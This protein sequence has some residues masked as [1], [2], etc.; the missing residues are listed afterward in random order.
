MTVYRN[1]DEIKRDEAA[2]ISIG[3]FDGVH[4]AHRQII[5]KVLNLS[6]TNKLRSFLITF[7]PHPQ[8]V[9]KNKSPEI[10]LLTTTRE[11]LILFEELGI[12]N[13]L[14]INFTREFSKT[15]AEDF[16]RKLVFAKIGLNHLVI[17]YDHVFGKNREG[18]FET[19]LNLGIELHFEIHRVEEIDVDGMAVSST[20]IRHFLYE[21]NIEEAN[22]LLGYEYSFEGIVSV[23]D[24]RGRTLGFPTIN[25]KPLAV[26]KAMPKDGVYCVK[27][28]CGNEW[29]YGMMNMGYRPTLTRGLTKVLEVN[30]FDFERDIYGKEV[31]VKF[32]KK[33]R[34]EKKFSSKEELVA[35]LNEDREQTLKYFN[36]KSKR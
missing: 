7:D 4:K 16:Y 15:S 23:G 21:G 22:L 6:R 1:I 2:V 9:L 18:S 28:R 20:K 33:L 13:V 10:K 5:N 32:Y 27:V 31:T 34:D 17:G 11:K 12:E 35:Q 25:I 24:N 14:V 19:L 3:T 30:I 36:I 29:F 26:N 8:E